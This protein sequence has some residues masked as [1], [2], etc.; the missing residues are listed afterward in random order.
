MI[1]VQITKAQL[2]E[3]SLLGHEALLDLVYYAIEDA[4]ES[5]LTADTMSGLNSQQITLWGYMVLRDEVME[6]GFLEMIV[7]GWGEFIF[8]NPFA[9]ALRE[10]GLR[11]LSKLVY[12]GREL[13]VRDREALSDQDFDDDAFMALYEKY[14]EYDDLDDAFVLH[15]EEWTQAVAQYVEAHIADFAHII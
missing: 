7:N 10:W 14:P 9:K 13:F 6:G 4:S 11:D 8:F 12:R 1:T 15:E 3:A 2:Q 5:E